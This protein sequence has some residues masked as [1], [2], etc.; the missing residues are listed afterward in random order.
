[1]EP[2]I[3]FETNTKGEI[4]KVTRE[5]VKS[6]QFIEEEINAL[7]GSIS[8]KREYAAQLNKEADEQQIELNKLIK[9]LE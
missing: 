1:M 4:E 5:V 8:S 7:R 9:E 6:A 2:K 3:T